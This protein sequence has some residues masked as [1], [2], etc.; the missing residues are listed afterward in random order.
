MQEATE[1]SAHF[2]RVEGVFA[3][4]DLPRISATLASIRQ[5]LSLV[6]D[7]PEFAGAPERLQARCP[8]LLPSTVL[9]ISPCIDCVHLGGYACAPPSVKDA[10]MRKSRASVPLSAA[11]ASLVWK[12]CAAWT[13]N[14]FAARP[15]PCKLYCAE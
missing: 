5:G 6:G 4:G 7:V 1:L 11:T 12:E 15:G 14:L 9:P 13:A 8:L 10:R 2:A 3:E